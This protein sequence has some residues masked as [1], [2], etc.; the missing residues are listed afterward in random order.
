MTEG[1][2]F[3]TTGWNRLTR[4]PV[5]D[6]EWITA[7][8]AR[9][10][11]EQ[12]AGLD[13]VDAAVVDPNGVPQ[14]RWVVGIGT[15]GGVRVSFFDAHNTIWRQVDWDL[16]D[17]RLWRWITIDYSYPNQAQTWRQGDAINS[18][19]T[20]VRPDDTGKIVVHDRRK[21]RSEGRR[22]TRLS[23]RS[24]DTYWLER[25]VF[26]DWGTLVDPG[27]S[28]YEVAGFEQTAPAT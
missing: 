21:P 10:L 19:E 9:D 20:H 3:Y 14:Q 16:I 15:S 6:H 23:G 4:R 27:P 12:F 18:V 1:T 11:Y 5:A 17:G 24:L 7:G 2:V 28:A 13:V 26:G 25:P 22:V 8:E